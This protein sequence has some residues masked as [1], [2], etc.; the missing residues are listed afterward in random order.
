MSKYVIEGGHALS[1]EIKV[2][3]AKNSALKIIPASILSEEKISI[4]NVPE[5]EDVDK[6]LNVLI[7]L[8]AIVSKNDNEISIS[9]KDLKSTKLT[10]ELAKKFRASIM[11]VG[12]LLAR[13]GEAKFPHPGGC[14][15]GAGGRPIDL[16]L[17][18]FKCLG[19]SIKESDGYYHLKAKKLKGCEFFFTKVSVTATE[20][21]MMCASLA[22]GKTVLKNCAME[23]EIAAL[24]DYLNSQGAKNRGRRHADYHYRRRGE[25]ICR[26]F[27]NHSRQN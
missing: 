17:E 14:V 1:G 23:P 13:F 12:P 6:A 18:G 19:A 7:D 4:G 5:I 15:I 3:G 9:T 25:I 22:E 8:G 11:F 27:Q 20:N 24:A 16:F 21:L 26:Q 10:D 2:N